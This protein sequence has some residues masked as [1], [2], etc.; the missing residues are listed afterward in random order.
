MR[1]KASK[2]YT[3]FRVLIA[4]DGS[5]SA[6]AALITARAIPWPRATRVRGVIVAPF[7]WVRSESPSVRLAFA[8]SFERLA[9]A[10]RRT[11]A[12]RWPDARVANVIGRPADRILGEA[13]RFGADVIVVGWRGHGAFRRLLMGSV[14]R[15]IVERAT[16]AVLVARRPVREIG[17][18]VI[19]ID[20]SRNAHRAVGLVARL[21]G[22]GRVVTVV[23]IVEPITLPTAGLLPASVRA[24]LLHNAAVMNKQVTRRAR[25]D[26]DAAATRLSRAGWK[27]RVN[28]RSGAPAETLLGIVRDTKGELLVVGARGVRGLRRAVLGSVAA[29][30]LNRSPV[31]VLVVR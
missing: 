16:G 5:P 27:V 2:R 8:K 1:Q 15:D 21:V 23:R 3:G 9:D 22:N 19:G 13:R 4:T 7:E 17:R 20:G 31:P 11:M 26:V 18:V 28:V 25:H 30:A 29:G 6:R 14:S 10:A 12:R 24:T